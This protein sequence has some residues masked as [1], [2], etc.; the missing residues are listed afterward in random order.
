MPMSTEWRPLP[1]GAE[2]MPRGGV[3]FRVWAPAA[4]TVEVI[5]DGRVSDGAAHK[6]TEDDGGYFAGDIVEAGPGTRYRIR[7]DGDSLY[8]DP[9]SRYQPERPHGPP[10]VV[11]PR[12]FERTAAGSR[13]LPLEA[14]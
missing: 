12:Q 4:M 8:A 5:L 10:E 2:V 3:H 13:A 6:L 9:A 14:Q 1:V 7:L 11:H